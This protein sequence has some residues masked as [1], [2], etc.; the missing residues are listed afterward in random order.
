MLKKQMEFVLE[1][2]VRF[3]GKGENGKIQQLLQLVLEKTHEN[4]E[5]ESK[6]KK[7]KCVEKKLI[8]K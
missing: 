8:E 1:C 5:V 4:E 7:S 6:I 2:D 3:K